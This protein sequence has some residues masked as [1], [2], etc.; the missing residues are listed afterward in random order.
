M[1]RNHG[2]AS[3]ALRYCAHN[4][5]KPRQKVM[6]YIFLLCVIF[7]LIFDMRNQT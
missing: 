1:A 4:Q 7:E 2:L 6:A 3:T 5:L